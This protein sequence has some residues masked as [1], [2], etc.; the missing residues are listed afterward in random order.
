MLGTAIVTPTRH[1]YGE[2][3]QEIGVTRQ[4]AERPSIIFGPKVNDIAGLD[5]NRE[6][7]SDGESHRVSPLAEASLS[8]ASS[9]SPTI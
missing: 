6:R 9:K 7:G 4:N 1:R 2:R 5:N 3:C 8:R